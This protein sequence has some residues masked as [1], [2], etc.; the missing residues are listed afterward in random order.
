M[1]RRHALVKHG[2]GQRGNYRNGLI[3]GQ[4]HQPGVGHGSKGKGVT[5]LDGDEFLYIAQ[6]MM[7]PTFVHRLT[8]MDSVIYCKLL[9]SAF[10]I[11]D[12]ADTGRRYRKNPTVTSGVKKVE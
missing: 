2:G 12:G 4:S 3:G 8:I 1:E 11:Q 6:R 10:Y 9:H 7:W 5:T